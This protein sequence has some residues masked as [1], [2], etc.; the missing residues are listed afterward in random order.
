MVTIRPFSHQTPSSPSKWDV[1]AA[2]IQ[3]QTTLPVLRHNSLLSR[4]PACPAIKQTRRTPHHDFA[5]STNT[6]FAPTRSDLRL[7]HGRVS[8]G[9][10]NAKNDVFCP[11]WLGGAA[12]ISHRGETVGS[13]GVVD[14]TLKETAGSAIPPPKP[15][16]L[17]HS[18]RVPPC[19]TTELS[20]AS[21]PERFGRK[22]GFCGF[23]PEGGSPLEAENA[24]WSHTGCMG[25]W[26]EDTSPTAVNLRRAGLT[27][28]AE[29]PFFPSPP[30]CPTAFAWNFGPR[31]TAVPRSR[32]RSPRSTHSVNVSSPSPLSSFVR[33]RP[34]IP[35]T[36]PEQPIRRHTRATTFPAAPTGAKCSNTLQDDM[37]KVPRPYLSSSTRKL[38]PSPRP[39]PSEET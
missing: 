5:L 19:T 24:G 28:V 29:S 33:H 2:H 31:P 23:V 16:S 39:P 34:W 25:R 30:V 8:R 32:G 17:A 21:A 1:R 14:D 9:D 6:H 38:R 11:R 18:Q 26:V 20:S 12:G 13:A 10:H 7:Q 35:T 27:V 37:Y 15:R 4:S 22:A 36:S 3:P